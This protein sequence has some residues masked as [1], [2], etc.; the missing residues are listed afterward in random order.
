MRYDASELD[1][2]VTQVDILTVG[3]DNISALPTSAGERV[4]LVPLPGAEAE[5]LIICGDILR[6]LIRDRW[7]HKYA[8]YFELLRLQGLNRIDKL[9][10]KI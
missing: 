9:L 7:V 5:G 3:W 6:A 1:E 2:V 10:S 8:H 4:P